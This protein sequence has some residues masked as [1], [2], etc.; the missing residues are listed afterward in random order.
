MDQDSF[1]SMAF[2]GSNQIEEDGI[3]YEFTGLN[4]KQIGTFPYNNPYFLL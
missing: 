1:S 4:F 2:E 3:I